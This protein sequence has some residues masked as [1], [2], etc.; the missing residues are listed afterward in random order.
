MQLGPHSLILETLPERPH[1]TSGRIRLMRSIKHEQLQP[2]IS[3]E[4]KRKQGP[5]GS[6]VYIMI[7]SHTEPQ[8]VAPVAARNCIKNTQGRSQCVALVTAQASR[9]L[10]VLDAEGSGAAAGASPA[11]GPGAGAGAAAVRP[12]AALTAGG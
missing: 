11:D 8:W 12:S 9:R 4:F 10:E 7:S 2:D 6:H 3:N 5:Q 1:F